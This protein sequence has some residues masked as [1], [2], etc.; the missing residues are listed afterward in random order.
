[1]PEDELGAGGYASA[2]STGGGGV[3][4]EHAY[5]GALLAELLLGGPVVGLGND[6]TPVRVGFQQS[7]HSPVDDLT[8][9]GEGPGGCRTLFIG[10]RRKPG[11]GASQEAFVKLMVDYL[12]VVSEHRTELEADAWRLGLAVE[13]PHTPADEMATLAYFARRQ[14]E[15]GLFR[16]A[17][18]APRATTAKVRARLGNVDDVVAAA[19]KM[20]E[21]GGIALTGLGAG[22]DLPW[23]LLRYLHVLDLRLEGDDAAGRT[24]LVARLVPLAGDAAGADDLRRR[25]C[26]LSAG[27]AV[28]AAM[29]DE[30]MLR[31]DL[32][33]AVRVAASAAFRASWDVLESLEESLNSRTR[34]FLAVGR[35]GATAGAGQV[36]IDRA[37]IR[38]SLVE[39]MGAAGRDAGLL[40][41]HG[42]PGA[43]KSAV[44]LA[45]VEEIRRAGG[46]V[47]AL[48]LRDLPSGPPLAAAQLLQAPPR[49]VFA[50]TAA[51]PVRLVVL[52]GAEAA[53]EAGPGLL[54][55]L[56]RA[57]WH[58]GLGLVAVTRDD[59][60]ETVT[61]TLSAAISAA[62]G[63]V[64]HDP[65]EME[66]P[67]LGDEEVSQIRQAFAG[68]GRLAADE[69][70]AWL[71]RRVGIIDILLRGDA[72]S[73]LPDGS[74]SEADV[75]DAVWHAWVR[76]RE[77]PAPGGATPDGRDEAMT[78][79]ARRQLTGS[80]APGAPVTTDPRALASLR[81]DGLL[82]PA[83]P[84][85][86]FRQGDEFSSDMVRDFA[87]AVLFARDGFDVLRQAG[88]PR[89]TLRAARMACQGMLISPRPGSPGLSA[90]MR[91]LQREFD[92]L[93]AGSGSR[94]AD[95]PW[96]AALT[97]GTA[98]SVL[99]EC[100]QDLLQPG[101]AALDRI[102]RLV[103]QR[104]SEEG[105]ADPAIAAPVV[106]FLV[107]HAPEVEAV[108]YRFA[109]E[110]GKLIAS[111]LR[112]VR[113]AEL[114]GRTI[115]SWRPLRVRVRECLLRP[116]RA[117]YEKG[118]ECLA[119]LGADTDEQA[120]GY[121]RGLASG[122]P[123]RLASCVELFDPTMSLA[124]TDLDL[125]FEMTEA[126]YF[127]HPAASGLNRH[128][129]GIRRHEHTHG[130]FGVPFAHW[131][132]G[133][134]WR[135]LPAAPGRALALINRMLDHAADWRASPQRPA[136][137]GQP[138]A[139][140]R[141]ASAAPGVQLDIPGI[142]SRHF[143]GGQQVWGWY[144]G[145]GVG[146]YPCMSALMAIERTADQWLQMGTPLPGLVTM[147]LQD[148]H[149][150][151]MPGLVVGL[152]ARHAEQVAAE[153]DPFLAS[154]AVWQLE[155][156]R[157]VMET[158]IHAQGRDDPGIPGSDRRNWT[159]A[160]LAGYLVFNASNHGNQDRLDA[161]CAAGR[162]LAAAAEESLGRPEDRDRHPLTVVRRWAS[163]LDVRN[164]TPRHDNGN[165]VWEWQPPADIEAAL[166]ASHRDLERHG[167]VYRLLNTYSLR[168]DP[169]YFAVPP[170]LPSAQA[171][172][173]DA[174][175]ARSLAQQPPGPGPQPL[176]AATAVAAA[177][178]RA[179]VEQ[180]GPTIRE[181]LEWAVVTVATALAHPLDASGAFQGTVYLTDA[182]WSAAGAAAC[183]LMPALT[184]PGDEPA[185]VEDD[186]DLAALGEIFAAAGASPFTEVR[187]LLA[188][189][190]GPV[191]SAPC[192]P[193]PRG[194]DQCRHVIAWAAVEA[195]AR[196]VSL[197]PL[198]FPAERRVRRQLQG[199]LTSALTGCPTGDL[200]LDLLTPPLVSACD[201]ARSA[202]CIADAARDLRDSLL[203]AYTRTA[204]H[205][206]KEGYDHRDED[207][208]AVAQALLAA[209]AQ[210][211][212]FLAAFVAGLAGHA[213]TLSET[214][215]AMAV[216]A[217]Y[218]ADARASLRRAWPAVTTAVLDAVQAGAGGFT[219]PHWGGYAIA[220][221]IPSPS[222]VNGDTDPDATIRAARDGWPTPRELNSL[223]ERILPHAVGYWHAADNLIGL[224]RTMPLTDQATVG[225]PWVHKIVTAPRVPG[226]GTFLAVEWL[227]SLSE[228]NA[229]DTA[230]R[231][232]YDALVDTLAR[233]D[234]RGAVE[235]QRQGESA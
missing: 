208:Y 176:D 216:A 81:S 123:H 207:Q 35:I 217:T 184:E 97:A 124:A 136:L 221:M 171:L 175:V 56:A 162:E 214:L 39:A 131:S 13:A 95:L 174:Q 36:A 54:H 135:L 20:A 129:M 9:T 219:D 133:P 220:E 48:S 32:S 119:L 26:E 138:G 234:Y 111:W 14:P 209:D 87:L 125:L 80:R 149:N 117:D 192:G 96:E 55:E 28:G 127:E 137:R 49:A 224:L 12:R 232:L 161:L 18:Q 122:Q 15:A 1:M 157:A 52:D 143:T 6:V 69:R 72:V 63:D 188:R 2:Y 229:V 165:L 67:P 41:V 223:I 159:M 218:S 21:K 170:P 196:D 61:G 173:A 222:P 43:G 168:P 164:Y 79:L 155:S 7:A 75:L 66:V 118:A 156:A 110:A 29:V 73:S 230:V 71:L 25:L 134:F 5:G 59:A 102:L 101:G 231:P 93:A 163:M 169:P 198:D 140:A 141:D 189:S 19:V 227:R 24:S 185:L 228:G 88:A 183:L 211:F 130:G 206:G 153:A 115:D 120:T 33:G 150:L 235:L 45:A 197:G 38:A 8:V 151:A 225:L 167:Q 200:M 126:Y 205:W 78:G 53:Q 190:L 152:L 77:L 34:R 104:F 121:L 202:S 62:A 58:A 213:R 4:L 142:G 10:V 100:V 201:A 146:P 40:V 114:A 23:L 76:S 172:A 103:S 178:L 109:E 84:R 186:E 226:M 65:A 113:R 204:V 27:Y 112:A 107:E 106:A 105:T 3:V 180:A 147:L 22:E 44:V 30:E 11:I 74:L 187:K 179:A 82:L 199:S 50:A 116:G 181:D 86:A 145:T 210:E 148:A 139:E 51:A 91:D 203:E 46:M 212:G 182:G 132:F 215:R 144:R 128:N 233:E 177:L 70:S 16:A 89:W 166:A 64:G 57:A 94:W 98:Q 154:P 191:W 83:G 92:I 160:D 158:G 37:D 60:R 108:R 193:G 17:V 90:R 99:R 31:R 68:L 42:E 47:V 194:S 85:F 195:G